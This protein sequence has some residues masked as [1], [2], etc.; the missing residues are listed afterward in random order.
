MLQRAAKECKSLE[1]TGATQ[2]RVRLSMMHCWQLPLL[3]ADATAVAAHSRTSPCTGQQWT[4]LR[5]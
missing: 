1:A 2:A 4:G 3:Y 5:V